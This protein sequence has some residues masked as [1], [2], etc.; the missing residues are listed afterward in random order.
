MR[1]SEKSEPFILAE[2]NMN[3]FSIGAQTGGPDSRREANAQ[4][5]QL[6]DMFNQ[7]K[8]DYSDDID[9]FAFILRIDGSLHMYTEMW[10]IYGA[11]QAKRKHDWIEV[12]LGIPKERWAEATTGKYKPWLAGEI[13]KGFVS[14]IN[15]LR[16]KKRDI[17]AEKLLADWNKIKSEFLST[18]VPPRTA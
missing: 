18:P 12:E 11:Q 10:G 17:K 6:R 1:G 5:Q 7:W 4:E 9:E 14:I 15:V 16:A 8:G 2:M 13:E 3:S